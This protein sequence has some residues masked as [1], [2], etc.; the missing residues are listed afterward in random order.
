MNYDLEMEKQIESIPEGTELLLHACCAPCSSAC[1]ERLGNYFKVTIFYFNP[2]I[3]KK[4]NI[5]RDL[6]KLRI[7]LVDLKLNMK[8]N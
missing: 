8:L 7:L 3:Q 5:K 2:N 1:L 4:M 6:M